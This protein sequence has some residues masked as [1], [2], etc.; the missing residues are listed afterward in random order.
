MSFS[1]VLGA[2]TSHPGV[3]EVPKCRQMQT[4]SPWRHMYNKGK[5]L[6]TSFSY[7]GQYVKKFT[8]LA[9]GGGLGGIQ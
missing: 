1:G 7:M 4:L 2:F 8:F 5:Q 9:G 3:P 6:T